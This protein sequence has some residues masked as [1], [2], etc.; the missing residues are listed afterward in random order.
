[1]LFKNIHRFGFY[2]MMWKVGRNSSNSDQ[3]AS[4]FLEALDDDRV[5]QIKQKHPGMDMSN[6]NNIWDHWK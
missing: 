1:M 5:S 3:T 4:G 6:W 2:K